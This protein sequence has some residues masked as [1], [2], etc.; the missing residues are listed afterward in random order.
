MRTVISNIFVWPALPFR[1]MRKQKLRL[2]HLRKGGMCPVVNLTVPTNGH[3]GCWWTGLLM[4]I[5][6]DFLKLQKHWTP[7]LI[8]SFR[9]VVRELQLE[10]V[11]W[12]D[13]HNTV[14]KACTETKQRCTL[15][16]C[17]L[18]HAASASQRR[19][20]WRSMELGVAHWE[21]IWNSSL[22]EEYAPQ[23]QKTIFWARSI[24]SKYLRRRYLSLA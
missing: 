11:S 15:M 24:I 18:F 20:P 3:I 16:T 12:Q 10:G 7:S 19:G 8:F 17:K 4:I 9:T 2:T 23:V 14:T 21:N 13:S 5:I 6:L 1:L 22:S